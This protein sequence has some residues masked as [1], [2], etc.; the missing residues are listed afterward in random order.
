MHS[1][2]GTEFALHTILNIMS[3]QNVEQNSEEK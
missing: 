1:V 3:G 2:R